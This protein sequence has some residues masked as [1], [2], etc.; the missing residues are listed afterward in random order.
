[1]SEDQFQSLLGLCVVGSFTA[2]NWYWY[3]NSIIFYRKNGFDFS[4][5]FGPNDY[6]SRLR[7][8]SF[9]ANPKVVFFFAMPF[10]VAVGT[11]LTLIFALALMGIVKVCYDCGP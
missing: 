7:R 5:D 6:W 3:I 11:L 8:D 10:S 1:M 2:Y 9:L 4:K